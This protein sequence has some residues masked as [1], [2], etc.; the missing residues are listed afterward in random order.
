MLLS[1]ILLSFRQSLIENRNTLNLSD[2]RFI[3]FPLECLMIVAAWKNYS[4]QLGWFAGLID[5]IIPFPNA[6]HAHLLKKIPERAQGRK[7]E[8]FFFSEHLHE[9]VMLLWY[10]R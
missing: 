4:E 1:H 6:L 5:L 8:S 7:F 9:Y 10:S 3:M 2:V